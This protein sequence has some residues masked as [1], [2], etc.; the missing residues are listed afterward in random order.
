MAELGY[1]SAQQAE[2]AKKVP[3][4]DQIKPE[5]NQ[6]QNLKA[7]HYVLEVKKQL[8]EKYGVKMMRK[9]GFTIKTTLDLRL[10]DIAEPPAQ[11]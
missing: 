2:E 1:I 6:Y 3:I 4:F 8:E 7:P 5:G 10:Q 11:K 9:G